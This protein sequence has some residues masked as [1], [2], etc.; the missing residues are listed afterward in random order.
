M[1]E[2]KH[3]ARIYFLFV[4]DGP[5]RAR[6]ETFAREHGIRNFSYRDYYPRERIN[7]VYG[8]ADVHVVTLGAPFVGI[9]IPTKC[10]VSMATARPVLFIGPERSETADAIRDA[11]G[12][13]IVDPAQPGAASSIATLLREWSSDAAT[14]ERLGRQGRAAVLERYSRD[15]NCRA[16]AAVIQRHWGA[17]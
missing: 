6:I 2:L 13:A 3:D 4:G 15:A 9:A 1:D 8:L 12:G 5:K 16:I 10:Y 7:S 11:Q 17:A 14:T